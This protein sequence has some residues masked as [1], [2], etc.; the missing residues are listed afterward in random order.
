M[1][2]GPGEIPNDLVAPITPA[3]SVPINTQPSPRTKPEADRPA[4][5]PDRVELSPRAREVQSL[6]Q[7]V[8]S[9]PEV[10]S[11]T[12]AQVSAAQ[13]AQNNAEAPAPDVPAAKVAEKLLLEG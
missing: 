1:V 13:P 9:E 3:P 8:Q 7:A 2:N 10:R 4:Q 12:V 6:V 5:E 11:E